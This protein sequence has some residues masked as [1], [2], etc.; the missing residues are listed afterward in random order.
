M[1]TWLNENIIGIHDI[2]SKRPR[3]SKGGVALLSFNNPT[4]LWKVFKNPPFLKYGDS[5]IWLTIPKTIEARARASAISTMR[6]ALGEHKPIDTNISILYTH[7]YFKCGDYI[8]GRA[9]PLDHGHIEHSVAQ[10]SLAGFATSRENIM[11]SFANLR[12]TTVLGVRDV[13]DWSWRLDLDKNIKGLIVFFGCIFG[14]IF[15]FGSIIFFVGCNFGCY[16]IGGTSFSC[17]IF[18]CILTFGCILNL[19]CLIFGCIIFGC[20]NFGCVFGCCNFGCTI[21]GCNFGCVNFGCILISGCI[22]F[23]CNFGCSNFGCNFGCCILP[24][25]DVLLLQE[26]SQDANERNF[27]MQGHFVYIAPSCG[28]FRSCGVVVH[29]RWTHA[30]DSICNVDSFLLS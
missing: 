28:M 23:G 5:R 22:N 25:W 30:I 12:K 4:S 21:F 3:Y 8:V 14:C 20:C 13:S 9:N 19:G 17:I 16:F 29:S 7:G 27:A 24:W 11:K 1:T 2:A 6:K 10:L 26:V 18:G 15:N